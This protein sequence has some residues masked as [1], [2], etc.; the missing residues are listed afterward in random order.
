MAIHM[1]RPYRSILVPDRLDAGSRN[2]R[3][4]IRLPLLKERGYIVPEASHRRVA[5][6]A[7]PGRI[8]MAEHQVMSWPPM[9]HSYK[10]DLV[11][12]PNAGLQRTRATRI[13]QGPIVLRIENYRKQFLWGLMKKCPYVVEGL[14]R[15]GFSGGWLG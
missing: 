6:P 5:P 4:A 13:S 9:H 1:W 8:L 10:R 7:C 3:L 15:T 11:S 12:H 2:L 14:R